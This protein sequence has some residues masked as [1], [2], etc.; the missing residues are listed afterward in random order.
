MIE[1]R[2]LT[3]FYGHLAAVNDV[4]LKIKEK[5]FVSILG[6]SGCGKSTLLRLIAGLEI[7]SKGQI[8]FNK[9]KSLEKKFTY[10]LSVENLE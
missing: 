2:N 3:K 4:S 9:K 10:L 5:E 1:C 7:P 8:F 6:P